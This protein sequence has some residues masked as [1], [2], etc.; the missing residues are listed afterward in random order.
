[1]SSDLQPRIRLYWSKKERDL[2]VNW[3]AGTS[4]A[5]A[6]YLMGVIS[7]EVLEELERRGFDKETIR[8]QIRK[9]K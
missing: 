2:M 8:F 7:E 3:D 1:M 5:T 4:R 6:R 9:K